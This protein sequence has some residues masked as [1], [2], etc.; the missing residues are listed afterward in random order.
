LCLRCIPTIA[1]GDGFCA[2]NF[3][4]QLDG[5][6]LVKDPVQDPVLAP[7]QVQDPAQDLV[8]APVQVQ[9][10]AQD[11]VLAPVQVQDPV[12]DPVLALALQ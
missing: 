9:D 3:G 11:P 5:T 4:S 8:L 1:L 12:Q 7:V 6:H 2:E 10:P